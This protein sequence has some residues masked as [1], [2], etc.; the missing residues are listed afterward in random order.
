MIQKWCLWLLNW[1]WWHILLAG[2]VIYGTTAWFTSG[3]FHPD[4]HFQILE[5]AN[6]K[7]GRTPTTDMAWE[8]GDRIRPTIQPLLAALEM[9]VLNTVGLTNPFFQVLLLR[10]WSGILS[11]LV[12]FALSRTLD[13]EEKW[14]K[15]LFWSCLLLWFAPMLSVRFSSE[16]WS[17]ICW[18]SAALMLL[19]APQKRGEWAL[20]G[21]LLGLSFCLRYQM[22]FALIGIGAWL[23]WVK[24]PD[25]TSWYWLI[26]GGLFSLALGTLSDFYF[27]GEW[28]CAPYNYFTRNIIEEKAAEYGVAPWWYYLPAGVVKLLPP[29]SFFI[30]VGMVWGIYK[31]PHHLFTWA[32]IPFFLGHSVVAHKEVRFLFPMMYVVLFF[33]VVGW[34]DLVLQWRKHRVLRYLA[35]ISIGINT[36][37]WVY[38]CTQPMQSFMPYFSYLYHRANQGPIVLYAA[39]ESPY[40]RVDVASY[41]YCHPN[42]QVQIVTDLDSVSA[43]AQPGNLYLY[44]R[45]KMDQSIPKIKLVPVYQYLPMW[46]QYLNFNH[47]QERSHI[48]SIYEMYPE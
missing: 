11:L 3:Y 29:I 8:F 10:I 37:V 45:L 18:L 6:W 31:K 15:V 2:A 46:V 32:F 40:K 34:R 24:K 36:L 38:F 12:Y 48:W 28:V 20:I 44:R 39:T 5:F 35:G 4:E 16:N 27:Y 30:I 21:A 13:L 41:V 33:A 7:L 42:I 9:Q 47:W 43:L 22:A 14:Q 19:Q 17:A 26:F 23:I 25:R 1:S